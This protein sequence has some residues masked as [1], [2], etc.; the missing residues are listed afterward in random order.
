MR[1]PHLTFLGIVV[2]CFCLYTFLYFAT[3]LKICNL[4]VKYPI[5][6]SFGNFSCQTF[7]ILGKYQMEDQ[8]NETKNEDPVLN[9][10]KFKEIT[11]FS[12]CQRQCKSFDAKS[13]IGIWKM[14]TLLYI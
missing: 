6:A 11:C 10:W 12:F 8:Q 9:Y 13:W 5:I 7:Q 2:G 4:Y 3:C 1:I 14:K